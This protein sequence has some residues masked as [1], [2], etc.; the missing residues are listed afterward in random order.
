M[1]LNK[2]LEEG[3]ESP[4]QNRKT[5]QED[6]ERLLGVYAG[7]FPNNIK[8]VA[9]KIARRHRPRKNMAR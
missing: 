4:T 9:S 8:E 6:S 1:I 3:E 7:I 2:P 5:I